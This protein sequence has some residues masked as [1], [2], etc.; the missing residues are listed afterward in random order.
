MANRK[1]VCASAFSFTETGCNLIFFCVIFQMG[2]WKI[3]ME[4]DEIIVFFEKIISLHIYDMLLFCNEG[5]TS[6]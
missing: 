5:Y 4:N 6:N 3:I 1:E 2:S